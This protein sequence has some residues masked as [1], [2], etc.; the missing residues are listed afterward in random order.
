M[1]EIIAL[2]KVKKADVEAEIRNIAKNQSDQIEFLDH[3]SLRMQEREFSPKQVLSVLRTGVMLGTPD[4]EIELE[5]GW[6]CRFRRIH[7]G[8]QITVCVK[9]VERDEAVCL[10]VTVF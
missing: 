5:R 9:L 7:A 2:P 8:D 3:A 10:I 1:S 6:R 4:W